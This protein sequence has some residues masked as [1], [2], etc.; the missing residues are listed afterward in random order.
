MLEQAAANRWNVGVAEVEAKLHEVVH[1]PSGRKFGYGELAADAADL[2]VPQSSE[3]RLKDASE[4]R[5]IGTGMVPIV[6]LHDITTGKAVYGQDVTLP[7]MKFAVVARPPVV[8][9]TVATYDASDT[10]RVAGVER[11][12]EIM[13]TPAPSK[14]APL[15]GVAVIANTTWAALKGRDALKIT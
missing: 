11:V 13:A 8:G 10:M 1:T 4:F 5:Y 15:G 2:P 12:V 3:I 7:G 14:F 9:G 6:D